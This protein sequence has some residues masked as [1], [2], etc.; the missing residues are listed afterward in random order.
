MLTGQN[1]DGSHAQDV[2]QQQPERL[3]SRLAERVPK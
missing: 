2:A 1:V 3:P